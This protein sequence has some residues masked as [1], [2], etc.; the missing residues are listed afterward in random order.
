MR[1]AVKVPS[2]C[3]AAAAVATAAPEF[4]LAPVGD[5]Q[6]RN[7]HVR[8]DDELFFWPAV[9]KFHSKDRTV[10]TGDGL[11][12]RAIGHG[13]VGSAR[14]PRPMSVA[15]AAH[16]LRKNAQPDRLLCAVGLR[17]AAASDIVAWL[18]VGGGSLHP[19]DDHRIVGERQGE[20]AVEH[21]IGRGLELALDEVHQQEGEVVEHVPR[22]H[23]RIEFELLTAERIGLHRW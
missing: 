5:L 8:A 7:G 11:A 23:E 1:A 22:R 9:L 15:I 20:V 13:A 16:A 4:Q 10:H 18:D 21:D 17:N 3:L 2:G 19:R 6:A 12:N 14:P